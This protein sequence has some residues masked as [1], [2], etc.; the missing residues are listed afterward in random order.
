MADTLTAPNLFVPQTVTPPDRPLPFIRA[1]FGL[2]QNPLKVWT[3]AMYEEPYHFVEWMGQ[4]THYLR[5]PEHLKGV[6]LDQAESFGKSSFQLRLLRPATGDGLLTTEGE[7]WRFQRRAASPAFRIDMLRAVVPTYAAAAQASVDRMRAAAV[8]GPIDV[9]GEM[10]R[11]TLDVIVETIL[12]GNDPGFRHD[13]VAQAVTDYVE[14]LGH[15]DVLD[16]LGVPPWIPRPRDKKGPRAAATLK[17]AAVDAIARRRASREKRND[18]LDYLLAARDP[19]T[20][21]GLSDDELRDNVVT[22]IGAGHETTALALTYTLYL[23][24][25]APDVQERLL[26]EARAACG[27][28]PVTPAMIEAMPFHEQVIREA[29]RLYPPVSIIDRV[30]RE[31]VKLGDVE[32]RKGDYCFLMIYAMHRHALLWDAPAAFDP[33]RFSE[34][35]AK[36]RHRFQYLPF[37]GG[38]RICIGMKFAYM[39][40]VAILATLV[41]GLA[42]KPNPAHAVVPNI[43]ITLRPE[44][45]MPLHVAARDGAHAG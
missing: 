36:G 1:V 16:V 28:A 21:K 11:A 41:R 43:R 14:S 12:G 20:G 3:R 8:N 32:I 2:V 37:G 6:L 27:D 35:R 25:N 38:P 18:L 40:A 26:A 30:A 42:F 24:A 34:E 45:G 29:M 10:Q 19:E 13:V 22:F 31:D 9:L 44:G 7:H 5:T 17:Q 39:E 4:R 15:P 23:I 33:E